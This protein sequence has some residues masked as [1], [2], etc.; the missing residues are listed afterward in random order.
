MPKVGEDKEEVEGGTEV[1]TFAERATA[2]AEVS[3]SSEA[4]IFDIISNRYRTSAWRKLESES[5]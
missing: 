4:V 2:K 5:K 1:L 3:H